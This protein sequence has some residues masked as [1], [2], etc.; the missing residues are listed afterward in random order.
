VA[1]VTPVGPE[2]ETSAVTARKLLVQQLGTLQT[3]QL[4][5]RCKAS[6]HTA[7]SK[8]SSGCVFFF[9]WFGVLIFCCCFVK[10]E[11]IKISQVLVSLVLHTQLS[12]IAD[13]RT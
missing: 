11:N 4:Y 12:W 6:V 9:C 13:N 1:C 8:R 5:S 7:G 3:V 2:K 10:E